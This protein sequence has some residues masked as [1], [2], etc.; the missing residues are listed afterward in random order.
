[1]FCLFFS[2][3]LH[4]D[5]GS[6]RGP[7]IATCTVL[8]VL[9]I[10]GV[11]SSAT[12]ILLR[13]RIREHEQHQLTQHGT[14][15]APL[16]QAHPATELAPLPQ[17]HP[18]TELAPLPQAHPADNNPDLFEQISQ[19]SASDTDHDQAPFSIENVTVSTFY[20]S[21]PYY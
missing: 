8:G 19:S 5:S 15:L 21:D 20:I 1:M 12:G 4:S 7:I 6:S 18:A 10:I 2:F 9:L 11:S 3:Q 16:P 13:R 14:E 17:A